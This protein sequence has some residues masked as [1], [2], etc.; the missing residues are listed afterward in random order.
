MTA[1]ILFYY[2]LL[3]SIAGVIAGLLGVGGGLIIVPALILIL[4]MQGID[5]LHIVHIAIGT[6]LATIVVTSMSSMWAHHRHGAV[7]WRVFKRL[8]PGIVVGALIGAVITD[9]MSGAL[10]RKVFSVFVLA[11]A[12]QMLTGAQPAAHRTVPETVGMFGAGG[13]IGAVSSIIGIGG[14]TMT[15]PFLLWCNVNIRRAVATS[16]A[17]GL[18]IAIAGACG[19]VLTGWNET[20]MPAWSS[21]YIY[22]PAFVGIV[23]MSIFFAPLGAYLAHRLPV[24]SLKKI[25]ALLLFVIGIRMLST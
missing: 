25:F 14:G 23:V 18:P 12:V 4:G 16:A 22:W 10:L 1:D 7:Q 21:G 6:S 20:A 3:G 5:Q 2:L 9:Y 17:C 13:I 11:A 24:A 8:V 19:Y 15:V